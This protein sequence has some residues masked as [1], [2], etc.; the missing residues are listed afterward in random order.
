MGLM[1]GITIRGVG[2]RRF[3]GWG[4]G[5]LL[6]ACALSWPGAASAMGPAT[7]SDVPDYAPAYP[8]LPLPLGSTRPED[9]GPFVWT[10]F[11]SYR[12]TNPMRSQP[13][14]IFGFFASDN[15]LGVP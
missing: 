2:R 7:G 1:R 4:V 3:W 9:G 8:Q 11:V 5:L 12:Q 14:A 10:Q 6:A 15:S 13:I